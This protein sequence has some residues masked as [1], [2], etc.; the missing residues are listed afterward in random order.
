[1]KV[2]RFRAISE[3]HLYGALFAGAGLS[4]CIRHFWPSDIL[5]VASNATCGWSWLLARALFRRPETRRPI[6]PLALVLAMVVA[7]AFTRFYGEGPDLLPRV[8]DQDLAHE[9]R[10]DADEFLSVIGAPGVLPG[11]AQVNLM[12]ERGA[13]Q[14]VGGSLLAHV[15]VRHL[16]Q[17]LVEQGQELLERP[18][19]AIAPAVKQLGD[20]MRGFSGHG[21]FL[22][23]AGGGA[24]ASYA[25]R[26]VSVKRWRRS[27]RCGVE[28]RAARSRSSC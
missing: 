7:G 6:W 8:I 13:L 19:V 16:V 4:F 9:V 15:T 26:P 3:T 11:E 25:L 20:G 10:G 1:V 12:N 24:K 27:P 17:F 28:T 2:T 23:S 5:A 14:R 21:A 22:S 18:S